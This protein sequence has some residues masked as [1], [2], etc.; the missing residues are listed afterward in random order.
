MKLALDLVVTYV[1]TNLFEPVFT[2]L[3]NSTD[4]PL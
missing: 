3:K 1:Y 4:C 2:Y